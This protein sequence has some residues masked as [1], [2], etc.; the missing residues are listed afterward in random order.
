QSGSGWRLVW[1]C[2]ESRSCRPVW[3]GRS[4]LGAVPGGEDLGDV[5]MV[6]A[7]AAAEQSDGAQLVA[8]SRV[9]L[10]KRRG[11]SL[12]ELLGLVEFGVAERR[13]VHPQTA[14]PAERRS[15][16]ESGGDMRRVSAVDH[17]KLGNPAG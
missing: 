10:S 5:A 1:C 4:R 15:I 11:I 16:V 13:S 9:V 3:A 12:V 14:N 8:E 6:G 17:E 2:V 7:A